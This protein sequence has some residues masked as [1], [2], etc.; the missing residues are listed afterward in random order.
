MPS[1]PTPKSGLERVWKALFYSLSGLRHALTKE[2]AFQQEFV[3][4]VVLTALALALPLPGL[5]KL[6]LILCHLGVM[7][8]ELL[9]SGLEAIVDKASPE[10]HELAKQAKDMGSAAVLLSLAGAA[11]TWG[12]SLI[13]LL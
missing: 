1:K 5:L 9:N 6:L 12:Y 2:S 3:L 8:V 11:A 10:Y 7:I 13:T 4:A